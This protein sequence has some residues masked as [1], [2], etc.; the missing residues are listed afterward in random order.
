MVQHGVHRSW[1]SWKSWNFAICPGMSWNV[2]NFGKNLS[3]VL[4]LSWNLLHLLS[5]FFSWSWFPDPDSFSAK[6]VIMKNHKHQN[7]NSG[8]SSVIHLFLSRVLS[9]LKFLKFLKKLFR[10]RLESLWIQ[11][12]LSVCN[13]SSHTSHHYFFLIS[14]IKIA[15]S[16][17]RKVTFSDFWK[18]NVS[19]RNWGKWAQIGPKSYLFRF[20]SNLA[21][22]FS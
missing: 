21:H 15:F 22:Y 8:W 13:K 20:F 2:L 9:F 12:R 19:A 10:T 3:I 17:S 4:E 1:K 6:I 7:L 5:Q 16:K 14:C 18:K 11:H